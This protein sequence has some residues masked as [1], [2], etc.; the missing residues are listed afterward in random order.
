MA[1]S[2]SLDWLQSVSDRA[3]RRLRECD[4][5][6]GVTGDIVERG[7]ERG[8]EARGR[9]NKLRERGARYRLLLARLEEDRREH[10][11]RRVAEIRERVVPQLAAEGRRHQRRAARLLALQRRVE[12]RQRGAR[13]RFL[14]VQRELEDAERGLGLDAS[15][16]I[17]EPPELREP[18][19]RWT[20]EGA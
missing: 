10:L 16:P 17:A 9:L 11:A 18:L 5:E 6:L 2:T 4:R 7:G 19:G 12:E 13:T 1:S 14:V 15:V 8:S 20:K 3:R